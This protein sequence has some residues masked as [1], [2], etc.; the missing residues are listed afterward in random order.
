MLQK[1]NGI[2]LT[3]WRGD[4][5]TDQELNILGL[6]LNDLASNNPQDLRPALPNF[7]GFRSKYY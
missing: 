1:N 2:K 7:N 4:D 6:F 3:A 5:P